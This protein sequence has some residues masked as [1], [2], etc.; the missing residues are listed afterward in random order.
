MTKLLNTQTLLIIAQSWPEPSTTAAGQHMMQL[1]ETFLSSG[2]TITFACTA[3]KTE[4]SENLNEIGVAEMT[5]QLNHSS[6][7]D[8]VTEL[9]PGVVLFDRYMVEEQFGWR[10][11]Q[12]A[13]KALR[14]LNTEDLHSLRNTRESCYKTGE[15][16][17]I[18]KWL[19]NDMTKR[20]VASIFRSDLSLLVSTHEMDLLQHE[21]NVAPELLLHLPFMLDKLSDAHIK[22]WPTFEER[23]GFVA[24]GNGRHAPNV[25]SIVFLKEEIW[26][27]IRK[28]LPKAELNIFGAYLT[29]QV[30]QM[31][32][33]KKG[34][35]IKSWK[36]DLDTKLQS[37]RVNL[38]P[39]R[40]GAGIKGK[41]VAAMQNG[42]PSVTT[43]IGIEGMHAD[44]PWA[45]EIAEN[46]VDFARKA[47]HLYQNEQIWTKKQRNGISI[48][49]QCYV[50]ETLSKQLL[51]TLQRLQ[52][53]LKAHR[54]QN[55]MGQLLQH[56]T[57]H[58]TKFMGKWIEEK[59]RKK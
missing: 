20:E 1:L 15:G 10:V 33:P 25:D 21:I 27:L 43:A 11:A 30:A 7:D 5:I 14:I 32:N 42:T 23:T 35:L 31:H 59:N 9:A 48:I 28:Q 19:Q 26:P 38:V 2:Y 3:A 47:V 44:L 34:F 55:F 6:F 52:S 57:L 16:F 45:G 49:N 18:E 22:A 41:L 50:K 13:P 56:Q 53:K 12:T 40:F 4:Y 51:E 36:K 54:H 24:F 29:Q 46:A 8:F 17:T 39:L 37:A 58:A